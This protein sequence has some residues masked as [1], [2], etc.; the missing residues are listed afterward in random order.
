M[1]FGL[2]IKTFKFIDKS[3]NEIDNEVNKF[4]KN[5]IES[6]GTID[7]VDSSI[8]E[9]GRIAFITVKYICSEFEEY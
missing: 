6:N 4:L 3:C 5:I 7:D 8:N 1:R 2:Q 9:D